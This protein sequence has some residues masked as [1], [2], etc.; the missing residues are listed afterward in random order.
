M[1]VV[2]PKIEVEDY[3]EEEYLLSSRRRETP[4]RVNLITGRRKRRNFVRRCTN[5]FFVGQWPV[6]Y[7]IAM[8]TIANFLIYIPVDDLDGLGISNNDS[9]NTETTESTLNTAT[10][11]STS[12]NG[13]ILLLYPFLGWLSE[14]YVTY[15]R[16]IG[17]GLYLTLIGM[18]VA[19]ALA[20]AVNFKPNLLFQTSLWAI[21]GAVW[22]T[23]F[24]AEGIFKASAIQFGT[25]QMPEA[26]SDQ[27]SSFVHWYY[28]TTQI[29]T[30]AV[31][32]IAII[33]T[34]STETSSESME[35]LNLLKYQAA[36]LVIT[37]VVL[38]LIG[39]TIF[40]AAK[41]HLFIQPAQQ[42]TIKTVYSVLR[43]AVK[44]KY[45]E[46]RS[47]MT[48]W[49]DFSPS[50]VD[51]G[52]ERY[53]GPFTTEEV[54]DTKSF[55]RILVLLVSLFGLYCIED[56][57]TLAEQ[58]LNEC[59]HNKNIHVHV[60]RPLHL[61]LT[62]STTFTT[63]I[64][65][66][67]IVPLYQLAI[68]P[69]LNNFVPSMLK[70]FWLGLVCALMS[71]GSALTIKL[72]AVKQNNSA[73]QACTQA[74]NEKA[75]TLLLLILIPQVLMG[76]AYL[77][78]FLTGLE[79]ILAQAPRNVQGLL[80]GL[81]YMMGIIKVA[82]DSVDDTKWKSSKYVYIGRCSLTFLSLLLY[83]LVWYLYKYRDRDNL[84]DRYG[85]AVNKIVSRIT[86]REK[87]V[88]VQSNTEFSVVSCSNGSSG[89]SINSNRKPTHTVSSDDFIGLYNS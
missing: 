87:S 32:L 78:V 29:G 13:A 49:E 41:R 72:M 10:L 36:V 51:L 58:I 15:Y 24:L 43:Y 3:S 46:K 77:L 62:N 88:I 22:F 64:V 73:D 55:L 6:L 14:A 53:G 34:L 8:S 66:V 21:V 16:S 69:V 83:S 65:A 25:D 1:A 26:S 20:I 57:E 74:F 33:T 86:H 4:G 19:C 56:T 89:S 63:S 40:H 59:S 47:A 54:E 11:L 67:V 39:V 38:A 50:R 76:F 68:K 70:R 31:Y 75:E 28:W 45:P 81:W 18:M 23:H 85:L 5:C 84:V 48:Y 82:N 79:F 9:N 61:L 17:V 42:N 27:L 12:I 52:K 44:H 30:T 2:G 80:I 35:G 37:Q 71:S 7:V 60:P